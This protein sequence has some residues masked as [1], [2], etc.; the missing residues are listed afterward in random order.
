M[1]KAKEQGWLKED[2]QPSDP[3]KREL[4]CKL[5][6]RYLQL[7]KLAELKNIYQVDF[8]DADQITPDALGYVALATSSGILKI[9]G[10]DF[11]PGEAVNRSEAAIALFRTLSWR[12]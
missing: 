6:L 7:N 11:A 9:K 5:L 3:V 4:L 12:S 10:Q 1:A 8:Q 2:L